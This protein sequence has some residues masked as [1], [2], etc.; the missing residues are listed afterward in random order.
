V[1]AVSAQV[2]FSGT[3]PGLVG[4]N[5][6]NFRIPLSTR[7]AANIPVVLRSGGKQSNSVTIP[8]SP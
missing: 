3:T 2:L 7:S 8:V 4:L 5:Q 1:D 6:I